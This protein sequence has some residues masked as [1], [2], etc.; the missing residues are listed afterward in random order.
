[1][2]ESTLAA[3]NSISLVKFD[4]I[5]LLS[6]LALSIIGVV[7]IYSS[8]VS[9]TGELNNSEYIKQI[10]WIV[11]G[12]ILVFVLFYLDY[13][14]LRRVAFLFYILMILLLLIT[15]IN[16]RA[17]NNARSWI[18]IG[19]LG[20]QPSEFAKLA[21][22]ILLATYLSEN[23]VQ[24]K[25][26][27]VF[28]ISFGITLLP[29]LLI[30]PQPDLGT[31]IVFIPIFL[32]IAFFSGLRPRYLFFVVAIGGITVFLVFF[33]SWLIAKN[34]L[35]PS[36]NR[37]IS[38]GGVSLL[39]LVALFLLSAISIVGYALFRK[40]YYYWMAYGCLV[41]FFSYFGLIAAFKVLKQYQLMRLVIF[42]DPNIDPQGAGWN[43][44][45]SLTA[46]GA[47]GFNGKGFLHG[48]QSKYNYLPQQSTDF[49]FSILGE[50][51]GFLGCLL[52]FI[53]YMIIFVKIIKTAY[54]ATDLFSEYLCLGIL[55]LL[56]YHFVENIGMVT[57]MMPVT[58]VPL[59]F[60]SYGGSSLWVG[61]IAIGIVISVIARKDRRTY[62]G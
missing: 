30:L 6:V 38:D 52:V 56:I 31:A 1:M 60:L 58:G 40:K 26:F 20:F 42:I 53:L 51:M 62:E 15:L 18:G 17:V 47:G 29:V 13:R 61:Y 33:F 8:A 9:P 46:V 41:V 3:R 16:G 55:G 2:K 37:L 35:S 44:L 14:F 36:V 25:S 24:I 49:I 39:F 5:L 11:T 59:I 22:I 45:Q 27:K 4:F 34:Q 32:S 48:T 21:T 57:G 50:E 19:S 23:R 12:T 28:I 54:E 43:I 10:I 7:F